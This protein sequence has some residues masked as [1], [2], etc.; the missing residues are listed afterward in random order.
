MVEVKKRSELP[1]H[2][3][4]PI[5]KLETDSKE[6]DTRRSTDKCTSRMARLVSSVEDR[7]SGYLVDAE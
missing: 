6:H 4:L 7:L 3:Q 1:I 2:S 5:D